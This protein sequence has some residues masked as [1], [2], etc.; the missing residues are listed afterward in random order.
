MTLTEQIKKCTYIEC[1]QCGSVHTMDYMNSEYMCEE[2]YR[3]VNIKDITDYNDIQVHWKTL[4][5]LVIKS[6]TP[7]KIIKIL[8]YKIYHI[9][10]IPEDIDKYYNELI[11]NS[12]IS[13]P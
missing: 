11:N 9:N 4:K 5:N 8:L 1:L 3:I 13:I 2:C 12:F 10:Y 7:K 6:N